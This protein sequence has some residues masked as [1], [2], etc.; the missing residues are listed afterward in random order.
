MLDS[1]MDKIV[2]I[3]IICLVI[4]SVVLVGLFAAMEVMLCHL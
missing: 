3:L 1:A 2:T 4:V